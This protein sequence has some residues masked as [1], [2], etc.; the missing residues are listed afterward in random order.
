MDAVDDDLVGIG[1]ER[2][3]E[4][5]RDIAAAANVDDQAVVLD[6]PPEPE[7]TETSSRVM[8]GGEIRSLAEQSTLVRALQAAQRDQWRLGVYAPVDE[9]KAVGEAAVSVLGL[10]I[11]DTRV[12]D[13]RPGVHTTLDEFE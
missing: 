1:H 8:V 9:Q 2:R 11:E 5:E 6:A 13:I 7:M 4:L 3:R 12:S 10:D